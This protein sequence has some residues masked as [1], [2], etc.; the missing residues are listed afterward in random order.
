LPFE[1]PGSN[2]PERALKRPLQAKEAAE[3]LAK[4]VAKCGGRS[5]LQVM[6]TSDHTQ[7]DLFCAKTLEQLVPD[8][9]R[10]RRLRPLVDEAMKQMQPYFG[11]LYSHT[12]RPGIA[13][14][15]LLRALLLQVLYGVH[16]ERRL[17]EELACHMAWRWFVGLGLN[18]EVWDVTVFTKNR[19]RFLQGD[20]A[21]RWLAAVVRMLQQRRLL[22]EEHFSVD[23]TLIGAH[24]GEQ[25][26]QPK[27]NPPG[28]GA[29]SGRRGELLKRD[30][31][32]SK[33]DPDAQLYR[34]SKR[35]AFQL[36]YLGHLVM[37]N[38]HGL[39]VA[40][41]ATKVSTGERRGARQ[42]LEKVRRRMPVKTVGADGAYNERD[43]VEGL[44]DRHI[45]AHVPAYVRSQRKDWMDPRL[46]RSR[47]YQLSQ[48][49]RKRIE[50]CFG[51]LKQ[52]GGQRRTRFRG[53]ARVSWAFTFASAVFNLVRL[54]RLESTC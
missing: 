47:S 21:Q 49:I 31:H 28:P 13:P 5:S 46:R 8:D 36:A 30:T 22:D 43:F 4:C 16:S 45:T 37:E 1:P 38:Q 23:A 25:S 2:P 10:L 26:Y 20:V 35:A 7:D 14:E 42:L 50:S 32:E 53:E 19:E 39:I 48:R 41:A 34:K 40:A 24:A 29:G 6:R 52:I 3:K 17:M 27:A 18:E 12:G 51:W 15:R 54:T 9:H 33:T 11:K 44:R